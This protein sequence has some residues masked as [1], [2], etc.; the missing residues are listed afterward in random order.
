V[1]AGRIFWLLWCAAWAIGWGT[2][3]WTV[4]PFNLVMIALSL[5]AMIPAFIP[6]QRR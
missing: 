2:I 5:V 6:K 1:T 4:F 3:G